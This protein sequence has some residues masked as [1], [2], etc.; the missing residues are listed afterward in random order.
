LGALS[1]G[2]TVPE[3]IIRDAPDIRPDNPAFFMSGI[4]PDTGFTAE[5]PVRL[6]TGYP[7][8]VYGTDPIF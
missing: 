6:D 8:N 5:Y 3:L 2:G 4:R 1:L 7:V